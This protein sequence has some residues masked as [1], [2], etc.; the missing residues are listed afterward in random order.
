[1]PSAIGSK[2]NLAAIVEKHLGLLI[3]ELDPSVNGG[4]A[5]I[6]LFRSK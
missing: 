1:M 4:F 3:Q 6:D 2:L 5:P